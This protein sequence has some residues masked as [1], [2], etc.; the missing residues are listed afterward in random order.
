MN[1]LQD[2]TVLGQSCYMK[3]LKMVNFG[4][5]FQESYREDSAIP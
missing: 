5:D 2:L 3:Y 1:D 4:L